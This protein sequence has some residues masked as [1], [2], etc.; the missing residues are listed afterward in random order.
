MG[1]GPCSPPKRHH[2]CSK[3]SS[4][5]MEL[6]SSPFF[7]RKGHRLPLCYSPAFPGSRRGLPD[8]C[9]DW[10]F[11]PRCPCSPSAMPAR[12]ESL[13]PEGVSSG[14]LCWTTYSSSSQ[15][16]TLYEVGGSDPVFC[17]VIY[18]S[19]KYNKDFINDFLAESVPKYDPF[20]I[21]CDFTLLCCPEMPSMG[22]FLSII[23][24]FWCN[25]WLV[26]HMNRTTH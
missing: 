1:L 4:Q 22:D 8:T 26:P 15:E 7:S 13:K 20:L 23:D 2:H 10:G 12:S 6:A 17:A 16:A 24:N 11:R 21:V 9:H 14:F 5:L 25:Q 3:C 19:P 18:R